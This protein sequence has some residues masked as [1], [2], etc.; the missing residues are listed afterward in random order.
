[1]EIS[2]V[3]IADIRLD[4]SMPSENDYKTVGEKLFEAF[5]KIGLCISLVMEF[6]LMLYPTVW[7]HQKSFSCY[8]KIP[9]KRY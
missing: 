2:K 4:V 1:M 3:D 9:R 6:P 8:Q 5:E 7:K